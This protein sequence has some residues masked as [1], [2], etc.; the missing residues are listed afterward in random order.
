MKT[1]DPTRKDTDEART[2]VTGPEESQTEESIASAA[3]AAK[4]ANR[5]MKDTAEKYL[6]AAGIKIDWKNIEKRIRDRPLFYLAIAAG[7]GFVIGGGMA[8]K[9]GLALLGLFG[10]KAFAETATNFGRQILRQAAG[11]AEARA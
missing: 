6:D 9:M 1:D 11:S 7:A 8:T 4:T 2:E 5:A 10:R 3:G